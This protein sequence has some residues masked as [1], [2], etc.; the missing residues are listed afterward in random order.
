MSSRIAAC[1]QPPVSTARICARGGAR[2]G[3]EELRVF[4][5]EDVVGHHAE[6]HRVAQGAAQRQQQ[7][8]LAAADRPAD[9]DGEGAHRGVAGE[10]RLTLGEQARAAPTAR[11]CGR[12]RG[13]SRPHEHAN[14]HV[15]ARGRSRP[16]EHAN[17]QVLWALPSA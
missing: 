17:D 10:R 8:C 1:G 2:G 4:A 15:R 9:P 5:R 11:A 13:R 3:D 14:D 16:H 6:A 12:A 7:R